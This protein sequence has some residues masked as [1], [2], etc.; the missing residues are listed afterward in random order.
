MH[1]VYIADISIRSR[2][3][4]FLFLDLTIQAS[5]YCKTGPFIHYSHLGYNYGMVEHFCEQYLE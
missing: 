5:R 3:E 4:E 2:T 1:I